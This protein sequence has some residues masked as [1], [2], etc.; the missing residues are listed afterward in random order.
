MDNGRIDI[1]V[2]GKP[3]TA[4]AGANV[5]DLLRERGQQ[6]RMV[7]VEING[8]IVRRAAFESTVLSAGDR[9]EIVHFVGGG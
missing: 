3:S 9:I 1:V 5:L 6:E 7:V 8:V 2:N 4:A